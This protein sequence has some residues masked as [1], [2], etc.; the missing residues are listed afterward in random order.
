ML[1]R[2][3][4]N[5]ARWAAR[6]AVPAASA[7]LSVASLAAPRPLAA[8]EVAG[9]CTTTDSIAVRGALRV[10]EARIRTE[11]GLTK[12]NPLNFPT[13]QRS[14]KA[15]YN[16][17][18]FDDVQILCD[19][20]TVPGKVLTV[21]Q[22]KE[23]AILGDITVSGPKAISE[24]SIKDKID[25]LIGRGIDPLQVA[26]AKA[27]ID[28]VYEGAGYYLAQVTIDSTVMSDG[29]IALHYRID[30]GR[31]LAISAIDILGNTSV[32]EKSV[33]GA[34]KTK[35]E[36]FFFFR[37][38]EYDDDKYVGDLGERIPALYARLGHVDARITKDTLV[39]DRTKG[40][41]LVQIT[42]D[43]GPQ[44]RVGSFEIAGNRHFNTEDLKK[45]YPFDGN[46]NK[47][48]TQRAKGLVFRRP[49]APEGVF[50]QE[51]WD[52]ALEKVNGVYRDNG[53]LYASVRPVVERKFVGA[54]SAPTANLRWE[55][56]EKNPAIVNRIEIVGNDFT[57]DDCIRRQIFLVPGGPF[58]QQLLIRSYQSIGNMNF[59]EQ[60][61][62]FPDYRPINEQGDVDIV[63]RVK[64]KRTGSVNF[65]ASMG[66]GGVGFGGFIG[67][68][69][70]NLFGLCKS[71]RLNWQ[72]GRFFNDFTATYTDPALKGTRLSG[73]LSAY[74]TQSRFIV[75]NLGQ[76]IRTGSQFRLGLPTPW[77]YFSTVAV[78][79]NG[80]AA[81]FTS[82]Q[83]AGSCS[84]NCFRSNVGLEYQYDTRVD[85]PFATQG[86]LR[87]VQMDFSGGP[88]GGTV[89]FQRLTTEMRG[90]ALLGQFG[91]S[92]PGSQ[93]IKLT[94][95]MTARSGVLFG[96]SGPFF[97][98]QQF[99]VGGVMF[100][101]QLR[102]YPEFS[103]T[104]QGFNPNTDQFRSDPASFGNAFMTMTG[105]IGLRFNQMFYFNVFA[106]AG[107]NWASARQINPTRLFRSAGF[108]VS[109]V[110]PL[111]PLGLDMAYGFD[112]TTVNITSGRIVKDPRWQFHFR[113]GQL[114]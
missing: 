34:M 80:E 14:L 93:P 55:I 113:L 19:L 79:Y 63:F 94:M 3:P 53:Y 9:R 15:L 72:Y 57:S 95:G 45:F 65:G 4:Q 54:D 35:P 33:V 1:K 86:S 12:G 27:K 46:E 20:E 112:R 97:F 75:G 102:G 41:G 109:T 101:Q 73:A 88:L 67:L 106:D 25:L 58:N 69:Q 39:V 82:G 105:E 47:T 71:G 91:G 103:I 87:S 81:T 2:V 31:R 64:E 26:K 51:K 96:N 84:R 92:N 32:R 16:M 48:L 98:Q 89:N 42:V 49:E 68:E 28:S 61:M 108:G 6:L 21:V 78:S 77:S 38:G 110:T 43:E 44:F 40:K 18:E 56:D 70:P 5:F 7:L 10:N 85:M 59:F 50:N 107:N 100:G 23:R 36:G 11:A 13:L 104:P 76:N 62:P 60:P 74:R 37:K 111:G 114:F 90:Y 22:V 29:R 8:Q 30:E 99:A 83:I 52:A 66:Q 24:R 17:G